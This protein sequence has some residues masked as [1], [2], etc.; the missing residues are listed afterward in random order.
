MS[1]ATHNV[2]YLPIR[3]KLSRIIM[4]A[5]LFA[6]LLLSSVFITYEYL[7]Q[8]RNIVNNFSTTIKI[9]ASQSEAAL[10]FSDTSVLQENLDSLQLNTDVVAGCLYDDTYQLMASFI[11]QRKGSECP[12][13]P[14]TN[15]SSFENGQYI[16]SEPIIVDEEQKGLLF[17]QVSLKSL[18]KHLS[19]YVIT[20]LIVAFI[21]S[22]VIFKFSEFLQKIISSPLLLLK[23]TANEISDTQD[24]SLRATK[25]T[26]D[27]IGDLV[28]TFN[29]MLDTIKQQNDTIV[30]DAELLDQKVKE[31]TAELAIANNELATSN[32]ELESF[33]YSVSHDLRAP[34]RAINGFTQALEEDCSE[35]VDDIGR[36]Y[37]KR[38]LAATQKMGGLINTLLSLSRVTRKEIELCDIDISVMAKSISDG[39]REHHQERKVEISIQPNITLSADSQL[40]EIALDNLIE[41]AWKYTGQ[42]LLAK[43]EFGSTAIQGTTV[44]FIKDNGAG[45]DNKYSDDLFTPFKRLHTTD[46]F[47]GTGIGLATVARIIHR[48]QGD[49][50]ATSEPDKGAQFY[51][52][53]NAPQPNATIREAAL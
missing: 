36:S 42:Q 15:L 19:T 4:T 10:L 41:N 52:T 7:S 35:Q 48:H 9:I 20:M 2:R 26:A 17:I 25:V 23:Q 3:K 16:R 34:L 1:E 14:A 51:F 53:I 45:F 5:V 32:Q 28:D 46:Q 18:Y 30:E 21:I 50:W 31:R 6:I 44:Y 24:Y 12:P 43:I 8:K 22:M 37:M 47:D 27:E 40:I 38:I 29:S 13:H 39:L 49:I 11:K 33:S